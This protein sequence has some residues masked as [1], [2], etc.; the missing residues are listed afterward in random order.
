M[1]FEIKT[2]DLT[3]EIWT[4]QFQTYTNQS[5][6]TS[7]H[8]RKPNQRKNNDHDD[9]KIRVTWLVF[10]SIR[11]VQFLF[12]VDLSFCEHVGFHIKIIFFLNQIKLFQG[13]GGVFID[14]ED[15]LNEW[16]LP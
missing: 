16:I 9:V 7:S 4:L 12:W 11:G 1:W 15:C 3:C 5:A 2:L 6:R 14:E 8:L 13:L 10:K